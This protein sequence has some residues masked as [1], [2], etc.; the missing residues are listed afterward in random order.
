MVDTNDIVLELFNIPSEQELQR[1]G[2]HFVDNGL[3][4]FKSPVFF[5]CFGAFFG[6]GGHI[7]RVL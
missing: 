4:L 3:P 5:V 6:G 2:Q 1:P 7:L